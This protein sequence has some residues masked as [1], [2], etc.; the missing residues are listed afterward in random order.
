MKLLNLAPFVDAAA[1]V[2]EQITE[3]TAVRGELSV[4]QDLVTNCPVNIACGISG[5]IEGIAL[6]GLTRDAAIN[7][8]SKMLNRPLR[9]F[10]Q[11]VS[12][13]LMDLG[14]RL[15]EKSSCALTQHGTNFKLTPATLI[16]GMSICVPT[17]GQPTVIVPLQFE[18]IATIYVKL[19]VREKQASQA[20]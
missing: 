1:E 20:A 12:A 5:D 14:E 7:I 13:A 2:C 16:R 10:D 6:F 9:V 4:V 19:S 11:M 8:A 17:N 3:K 18:N 15:L